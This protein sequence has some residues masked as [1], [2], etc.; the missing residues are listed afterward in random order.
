MYSTTTIMNSA[1]NTFSH[2]FNNKM[3]YIIQINYDDKRYFCVV[4]AEETY[5]A[6]HT[7]M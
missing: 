5:I 1:R 2:S 4:A 3:Q 6:T 7:A